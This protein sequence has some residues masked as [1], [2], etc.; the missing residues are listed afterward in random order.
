[1]TKKEITEMLVNLYEVD[2]DNCLMT[3][4]MW[5]EMVADALTNKDYLNE[6]IIIHKE[7]LN[8]RL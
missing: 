7:Y 5:I 1:M 8:E 6:L 4:E 3:H 2:L